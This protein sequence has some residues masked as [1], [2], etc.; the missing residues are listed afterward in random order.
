MFHA[1]QK[2]QQSPKLC[3]QSLHVHA[4]SH[5][6]AN[7]L[8]A[9]GGFAPHHI[10]QAGSA[11]DKH[12]GTQGLQVPLSEALVAPVVIVAHKRVHYL[13]KCI[14]TLLR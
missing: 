7:A 14:T 8:P 3:T 13:A 9:A 1:R 12:N 5:V 4:L 6:Q 2:Q 10:A 11:C